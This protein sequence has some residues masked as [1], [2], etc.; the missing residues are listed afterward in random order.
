MAYEGLL[1]APKA[2]RFRGPPVWRQGGRSRFRAISR[3]LLRFRSSA[4]LR[5]AS[6]LSQFC[7]SRQCRMR[8]RLRTFLPTAIDLY[9]PGSHDI[10]LLRGSDWDFLLRSAG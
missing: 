5:A 7:V 8:V 6:A 9:E 1:G 2:N 10:I 4:H 3:R